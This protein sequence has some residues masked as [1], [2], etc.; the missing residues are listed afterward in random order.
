MAV[1]RGI[2]VYLLD[3]VGEVLYSVVLNHKSATDP[4]MVDVLPIKEFINS[5][6]YQTP[7]LW[8]SDG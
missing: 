5:G 7:E 2:E 1:N 8:L 6:G 4:N 3:E